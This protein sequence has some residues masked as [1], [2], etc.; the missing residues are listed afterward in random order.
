[1]GSGAAAET[2]W[3]RHAAAVGSVDAVDS[4]DAAAAAA[5]AAGAV[6]F[7]VGSGRVAPAELDSR[8]GC[9]APP[10]VALLAVVPA[11]ALFRLSQC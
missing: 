3:D 4:V 8:R 9:S 7:R 10:V 11:S 2:D 6:G 1:M 5:A